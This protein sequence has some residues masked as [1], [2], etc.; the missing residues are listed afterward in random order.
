MLTWGDDVEVHALH[1]RGWSISAIACHLERDRKTIRAYVRGERTPG[2][3]AWR[4]TR[5]DRSYR[6]WPP[7]SPT[8]VCQ[9]R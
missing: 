2:S 9:E 6:I 8:T 4:L 3:A 1:A 5:W 7:G